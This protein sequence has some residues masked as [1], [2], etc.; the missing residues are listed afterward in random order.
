MCATAMQISV[1]PS[2]QPNN[3][4]RSSFFR[5]AVS[6]TCGPSRMDLCACVHV[7]GIRHAGGTGE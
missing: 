1:N 2:S 3:S 5:P 7:L 6:L 4:T